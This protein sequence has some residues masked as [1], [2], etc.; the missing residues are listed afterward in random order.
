M[1][2]HSARRFAVATLLALLCAAGIETQAAPQSPPPFFDD[3]NL[4]LLLQHIREFDQAMR[5]GFDASSAELLSRLPRLW[6]ELQVLEGRMQR[7]L[8]ALRGH[9]EAL[10]R[11]LRRRGPP[12]A[13][14]AGAFMV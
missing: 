7:S 9:L 3:S 13:P 14:A 11:E 4:D 12:S 8:P 6:R 10:E 2:T 5:E 1:T